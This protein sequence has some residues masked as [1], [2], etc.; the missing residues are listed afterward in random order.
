MLLMTI[1]TKTNLSIRLCF[2][3]SSRRRHTRYWLDWSSDVCSSDLVRAVFR[4]L[5]IHGPLVVLAIELA[6]SALKIEEL[7]QRP[8]D[9]EWAKDVADGRIYILQA[10]PETEIEERRVGIECRS[11]R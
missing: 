6:R 5:D 11:E 3:F 8:M 1:A 7:Y 4:P 9:I 10:R 2:F